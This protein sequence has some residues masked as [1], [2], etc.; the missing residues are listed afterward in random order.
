MSREIGGRADKDGNEFER[1]WV[2]EQAFRVLQGE[3]T[4]IQWE[5][6]G[7]VGFGMELEVTFPD[8]RREV[9]QC[10]I[11]QGLKGQWSAAD[12]KS[13][14]VLNAALRHLYRPD[15]TGF[16]FVSRDPAVSA[17]RDLVERAH[18]TNDDPELFFTTALSAKGHRQEFEQL[19]RS[20]ELDT[21]QATDRARAFSLLQ[22]LRF[23]TGI[24]DISQR[25]RLEL[26]ARL[27]AE[28]EGR[29]IV[30]SL[31]SCLCRNLGQKTHADRISGYLRE[32]GHPPRDL[33][34]DPRAL[35]GIERLQ[36]SFED[37]LK[38]LLLGGHL[39]PRAETQE[40]LRLL[41]D[42]NG[43][44]I[45]FL[46]GPAGIGK[47]DVALELAQT[48]AER[49][50]PF[51]PIRL[52]S[53]P[54]RGSLS[55]YSRDVL[56][57]P[58]EPTYCLTALAGSRPAI[59]LIDQLD[60]LRWT[61][62]HSAEA[63]RIVKDIIN[64]ALGGETVRI[65]LSCRTFDLENDFKRW[66]QE[67]SGRS[68]RIEVKP[69]GDD[70][71]RAFVEKQG[72]PYKDL[73]PT[74][75]NLL[76]N[77]YTLFL[78]WELYRERG[79][80]LPFVHKAQLLED[81]RRHLV[82]RLREMGQTEASALLEDLVNYLDQHGRLDAPASLFRSRT[83]AQEALQSLSV[84][85][86]PRHGFL[87]FAHQSLLDFLIAE[88]VASKA[89]GQGVSPVDWLRHND[90]S[91][92][93][94]DQLRQLLTLLRDQGPP[95]YIAT[96]EEIITARDIRFH[97]QHL[98]LGI[99]R[100]PAS[101]SEGELNL[102]KRLLDT[103]EWLPHVLSQVLLGSRAWFEEL[104]E[105]G[106][107]TSWL[108]SNDDQLVEGA[109]RACRSVASQVPDR[110]ERLLGPFWDTGD[111]VWRTKIDSVL[112]NE[113]AQL[114]RRMTDW[115]L[116]RV[117]AGSRRIDW[118]DLDDLVNHY[119]TRVAM[120]LEAHLLKMLDQLGNSGRLD[121]DW[122]DRTPGALEKACRS[123]P[124]QTWGRLLPILL[125]S[126]RLLRLTHST[127][128]EELIRSLD[129]GSPH[130]ALKKINFQ[131]R[132]LLSEAGA[133]L[134]RR[135]GLAVLDRI[136]PLFAMRSVTARR[137]VLYLFLKGPDDLAD[138]AMQWLYSDPRRLQLGSPFKDA[139]RFE[140]A[141]LLIERFANTCSLE[142]FWELEARLMT[143]HPESEVTSIRLQ[144][145]NFSPAKPLRPNR[146]GRAQHILLS[147]LPQ[148][149]M[150]HSALNRLEAWQ[151][152][153]GKPQTGRSDP[154]RGGVVRSPIPRDKLPLISDEQWL[155]I[156]STDWEE[157]QKSTWG[158]ADY[159]TE[160]SHEQFARDFGVAA[161]LEPEH[162][163]RLALRVP[164]SA[165]NIYFL[166]LLNTLWDKPLSPNEGAPAD[167]SPAPVER[168]EELLYYIKGSLNERYIAWAVCQLVR[169]RSSEAWSDWVIN[170]LRGYAEYQLE[171]SDL[172][173][174]EATQG[175]DFGL[176][177]QNSVRGAA[178]EA[179]MK[180]LFEKPDLTESFL[181]MIEKLASDSNPVMRG[182]AQ[183]LCL[184]L[185]NVDRTRAVQLFLQSCDHLDDRVLASDYT[186]HVLSYIWEEHPNDL[187][188]LLD[189][190]IDSDNEKA[191]ERG[192]F[193][194]TVGHVVEG[195]YDGLAARCLAGS[196]A[197]R[198]GTVEAMG[199][200]LLHWPESKQA[201][202][203]GLLDLLHDS[204]KA[205]SN[206]VADLL[207]RKEIL[208]SHD[209]STGPSRALRLLPEILLRLYEQAEGPELRAV[210][211]TCLDAW[212][213]LLRDHVDASWDVLRRLDA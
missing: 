18:R 93:R 173:A 206:E 113:V 156:I 138:F 154:G 85:R 88:R 109:L 76:R 81:Y 117:R 2:V 78:W 168:I 140:P 108:N 91:L 16:V 96:L 15:I 64:A 123:V 61:G 53:Q 145:Q 69:L 32:T 143:F 89:L 184:P 92:F 129:A 205:A 86:A 135:D 41:E 28:G 52:D 99:L 119:P 149:R 183:R 20:W 4:S 33:R 11:E 126:I 199:Q 23:E 29:D 189:K 176:I 24:W 130:R 162:F 164:T 63:L 125:R 165:P 195:L 163:I 17:L 5:L 6:P 22:R 193:W 112:G 95:L 105:A 10:K 59:L 8:G 21:N 122:R 84:L 133:E 210:R 40:L 213:S 194:A 7:K 54:P 118:F 203:R 191:A 34:S 178:A 38:G 196:E 82:R 100:E 124:E 208:G 1:L 60:A 12:L 45:V 141:R 171:P 13:A 73:S 101:P 66:E 44:R 27:F 39:L 9:H 30:D 87:T 190:M 185:L 187:A 106:L 142:I 137:L 114:T 180:L 57:L 128:K 83:E 111:E 49:K 192:A 68:Q 174:F 152:K 150:S 70:Q 167:W 212:D 26:T 98:A 31:G 121:F 50:I 207:R 80:P 74:Q 48:L 146:Y 153:F 158:R 51:L 160:V 147:A 120:L 37:S 159:L 62:G 200:L 161:R 182:A 144:H 127:P 72:A 75:R 67:Y 115:R 175:E 181:P 56:E 46:H 202:L 197:H 209:F 155:S 107:F 148:G 104:D 132:R 139:S 43:P 157:R 188:P 116:V 42:S 79:E 169:I 47:S 136:S 186:N 14:G 65:V 19:C 58:A 3:A 102:V 110:I 36:Q 94:R 166:S 198:K 177:L 131:L 211:N 71:V 201:A 170:L 134:A 151:R 204:D 97:L 55:A 25:H 90:Q 35:S 179:L 103:K 77:P 172:P